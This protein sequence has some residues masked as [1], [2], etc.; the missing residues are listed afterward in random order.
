MTIKVYK[1]GGNVVDD[2]AALERFCKEFAALD[3]P[4]VLVHGGGVA[5]SRVQEMMGIKPVKIQ[6]RRVTDGQTLKVV[7]GVYAGLCNKNVVALLQRFHCNAIGLSGCDGNV[8]CASRRA[9]IEIDGAMVDF[10]AVGDVNVRSVNTGLLRNLTALGLVPVLNAINH[11][12]RGNLLNTNADTVASSVASALG[13]ELVV[14]FE[15]NGV[16]MDKED[17]DSV[18][19][20]ITPEV[21]ERLKADGTVAEGMIP[22]LENAFRCLHDGASGVTIRSSADLGNGIGTVIRM[23]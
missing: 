21:F 16:L 7:T 18:I 20:E 10:G 19:P 6:G 4:R 22:K 12:G 17:G 11:D 3:G 23:D 14:C 5:A 1:I 8:I 9:P 13:A 2:E 15:K